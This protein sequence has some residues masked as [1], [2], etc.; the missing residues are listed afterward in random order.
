MNT[1]TPKARSFW[2][3]FSIHWRDYCSY[4]AAQ[5]VFVLVASSFAGIFLREKPNVSLVRYLGAA[6]TMLAALGSAYFFAVTQS[7]LVQTWF[8]GLS[9]TILAANVFLCIGL[10]ASH[11][12]IWGH[13]I[14][15]HVVLTLNIFRDE[16]GL[17]HF[18]KRSRLWYER[19]RER[20][21]HG[22]LIWLVY[23]LCAYSPL[24]LKH[25]YPKFSLISN[26]NEGKVDVFLDSLTLMVLVF[27]LLDFMKYSILNGP[28][29]LRAA[30]DGDVLSVE[31]GYQR[32]SKSYEN[33]P[34]Q[35]NLWVNSLGSGSFP[36]V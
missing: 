31:D 36:S 13:S 24:I 4:I 22:V 21:S 25:V 5:I 23:A 17:I 30:D 12:N 6:V 20:L 18:K 1:S 26:L 11:S 19:Y 16:L 3:S 7:H 27:E 28:L 10:M 29:G 14:V 9:L 8:R 2:K 32:W 15:I 33:G 34:R 35:Q